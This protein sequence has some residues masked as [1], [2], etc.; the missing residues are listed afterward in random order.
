MA[1]ERNL[2]DGRER[3]ITGNNAERKSSVPNDLPDNP[4]DAK[5]LEAEEV[6]MDLPD[7][8]DIPG[9]EFVQVPQIGEMADTTISSDDEEGINVIGLNDDEGDADDDT[10]GDGDDIGRA[11]RAALA[12]DTYMPT[13]DEDNLR[14]ARMDNV[15]FEGDPLNEGSFGELQTESDLDVPG[16]RDET[17]T[18]SMGQGDEENKGYSVSDTEENES[19]ENRTGA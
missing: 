11:E 14:Q 10:S 5:E 4:R 13:R 18:E 9:Q 6:I 15:D 16:S 1:N 2:K 12:D 19:S 7:V 17:L 8:K 3:D